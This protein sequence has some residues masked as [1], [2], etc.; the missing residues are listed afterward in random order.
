MVLLFA[1]P[2]LGGQ[3]IVALG[4]RDYTLIVGLTLFYGSLLIVANSLIDII[5]RMV[6]PRLREEV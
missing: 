2:G 1:I 4:D 6:D 3:F 5:M